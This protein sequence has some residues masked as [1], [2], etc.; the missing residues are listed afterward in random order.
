[1]RE[2]LVSRTPA[3]HAF[4][5]DAFCEP[6]QVKPERL[7]SC[8]LFQWSAKK[9][10]AHVLVHHILVKQPPDTLV[11]SLRCIATALVYWRLI[12][13]IVRPTWSLTRNITN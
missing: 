10:A 6:D 13:V 11:Q 12:I 2:I 4:V 7:V 9:L 5:D 1:M 3:R 8:Q